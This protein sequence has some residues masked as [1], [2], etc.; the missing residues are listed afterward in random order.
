VYNTFIIIAVL[1]S[2]AYCVVAQGIMTQDMSSRYGTALHALGMSSEADDYAVRF[3]PVGRALF[4]TSERSGEAAVYTV[5]PDAEGAKSLADDAGV[6]IVPGTINEA[7]KQRAFVSFSRSGDIVGSAY[8][9]RAARPYV[10]IISVLRDA[11]QLNAGLPIEPLNGEF[12]CSH[13]S[14]SSNGLRLVMTRDGRERGMD[15][16]ISER[17]SGGEWSEPVAISPL[18]NSAGHE[19]TP[20]FIGND[21]LLFASDGYGGRGGM[22]LFLSVYEDGAWQEPIPLDWINTEFDETDACMLPDGTLLFASN[23]PGGNGGFDLYI[24]PRRGD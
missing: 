17:M 2:S 24:V 18:L 12:F 20:V 15:I 3:D 23:R 9:M 19:M 21:S 6:T 8:V 22:D 14:I 11:D 1:L 13:P 16:Y 5:L 4:F 7:G 10:G